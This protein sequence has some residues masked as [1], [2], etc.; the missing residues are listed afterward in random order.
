MR[1]LS[2]FLL[3]TGCYSKWEVEDQDGDGHS[4]L[5]GD[6]WDSA[7]D[8]VPPPSALDHGVTASDIH[9]D[10][11]DLPYD[12]IDANCDGKDDFDVDEDGFVPEEYLGIK[13]LGIT[14]SGGLAGGDC[15]DSLDE[16]SSD[17]SISNAV[18]LGFEINPGA[19][20]AFYDG[21]DQNCA[22]DDDFD[23][24]GDGHIANEYNGFETQLA[25]LP[26]LP[27][28]DCFDSD[29]DDFDNP[30]NLD[31]EDVN[32]SAT[33]VWYDGADQDCSGAS[34]CDQD[35]DGFEA[36]VDFCATLSIE[37]GDCNDL[38][39]SIFPNPEIDEIYYNGIDDNC[40]LN[41][42]D[43]DK[44]G[45]GYWDA[46]YPFTEGEV[47]D[48]VVYP[49]ALDDCWDDEL[50]L[51][52][53]MLSLNGFSELTPSDVHPDADDR[54]YDGIDQDCA[55]GDDFDQDGDGFSAADYSDRDGN[56]GDDCVDSEAESD[57]AAGMG[58]TPADIN[59]DNPSEVYY[60]GNDQN[61][62][63]LSDFDS[64]GDGQNSSEYGGPDCDDT[65]A[66]IFFDPNNN[67][68]DEYVS[69][70]I[71]QNCD[72]LELCYLDVDQDG[73][74]NPSA[75]VGLSSTID[76]SEV[77]F[78]NSTNDCNDADDTVYPNALEICDGQYNDCLNTSI[79]LDEI[80]ND[81]DGYVECL[82]DSGGW[83]GV[84][85]I[86]GG[87]CD[88]A[89]PQ[90][91]PDISWYADADGDGFGDLSSMQTAC[92]QPTGFV[93][94]NTDCNDA[95]AT[96]FPNALE[97]C[98]GLDNDCDGG[99]VPAESDVDGDGYTECTIDAGGWDGGSAVVGGSDCDDADATLNFTDIDQ[100]GLS[101]CDGDCDDAD[102][103]INPA[104]TEVCD[105][106]DNNC[107]GD[108]DDAD[109]NVDTSIGG[110]TFY[111]DVDG[112]SYGDLASTTQSC[113]QP[114]GYV[115]NTQDCD[116]SN[117]S[118]NPAATEACDSIDNDCDG[119]IDDDDSNV[120]TSIGGSIFYAD[121]DL[122]SYGDL[123]SMIQSC[124]QPNGYVVNT[125]DCDDSN[126][127][128]NP[129]ATEACDS[130]DNDCDGDIDDDDSNVDTSIG[131]TTFYADVDG[132]SYG[133]L[134]S[135]S[136][137]CALPAGY[138][139][140]SQDC[141]DAD[142]T[143]FPGAA[144][145]CD[146]QNN[147]CSGSISVAESDDDVDGYVEC[148]IDADGWDGTSPV[149]G[150]GD[151]DDTD[152]LITV[153]A[154]WYADA[155]LDGYGSVSD[156]Q[157]ACI[158]PSGYISDDQDCDDDDNAINPA[159]VEVCDSI[160]NDCDGDI[161]DA[162]GDVDLS[163]GSTFYEDSDGDGFG[164]LGS[165][166]L[167]CAEPSGYVSDDQDCDDS[168]NA[169]YPF[170]DETNGSTDFNCDGM[171][172]EGLNNCN[173]TVVSNGFFDRYYLACEHEV[174][175]WYVARTYC[176]DTGYTSLAKIESAAENIAINNFTDKNY[177][178]GLNDIDNEDDFE[179]G[180]GSALTNVYENWK[181]NNP[182]G[183]TGENCIRMN[184]S[185]DWED[186]PCFDNH[187]FVCYIDLP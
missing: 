136:L 18:F 135:T 147:A 156:S 28:G 79:P 25:E 78:A 182:D 52:A 138:L 150:G 125:Q 33:E 151:C 65:T 76:C 41:D 164:D 91:V 85:I 148:D 127:S 96:V 6:C 51:S 143:V 174:N 39:A 36:E 62:D 32:P 113:I 44:D 118:I 11:V 60:D 99:L 157:V 71:D 106:V 64:D 141:N 15:F 154:V 77:G 162:D 66:D 30:S 29:D 49:S 114:N 103:L 19:D 43:G 45:D 142:D 175:S 84:S 101:S 184:N 56:F 97:L 131:G 10:A 86:G 31:P 129:A 126:G 146:G 172:A 75:T 57:F 70:G 165:T 35:G 37:D 186:K 61:C 120:D 180:D 7:Q 74:G 1:I 140:D 167:S 92:T 72:G 90:S 185:G 173:S 46:N 42:G 130:I 107:D 168:D 124:I 104:A 73:E 171:E 149:I 58:V 160:D 128:I 116:D 63:G 145:L 5:E 23:A 67:D 139:T 155:D 179:W 17:S 144:E 27:I 87:D 9:V 158:Q 112:D 110:T 89:D 40:D 55:F 122:D 115:A 159:A 95:D 121:I 82:I 14:T 133:D 181:V 170:A 83:N 187:K 34:D 100:D 163:A 98:D 109:A 111:A 117:G 80:D 132:D 4:V 153:G 68:L 24:D 26:Q 8:P 108:V 22:G 102:A 2:L 134:A 54:F 137:S 16:V 47:D 20:D 176:T 177:W 3:G 169:I 48:S 152:S 13:T 183:G 123:A 119:D 178:L 88:D 105:E 93:L 59:P 21:I 161:D 166:T 81:G 69:D 12:G 53:D 38:D 50:S 94:N